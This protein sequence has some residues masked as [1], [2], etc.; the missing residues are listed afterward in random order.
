VNEV[1]VQGK[2]ED[3]WVYWLEREGTPALP[4]SPMCKIVYRDAAGS[5]ELFLPRT[6]ELTPGKEIELMQLT[7]SETIKEVVSKS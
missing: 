3:H 7:G 6:L 2:L 4:L 1:R 5:R